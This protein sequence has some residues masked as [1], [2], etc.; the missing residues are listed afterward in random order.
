[1]LG[2]E[3]E[4]FC[5]IRDYECLTGAFEAVSGACE[6]CHHP[7]CETGSFQSL[8]FGKSSDWARTPSVLLPGARRGSIDCP[9]IQR[10]WEIPVTLWD[11]L[12]DVG[13]RSSPNQFEIDPSEVRRPGGC[14][15]PSSQ[16]C[17]LW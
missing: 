1:M 10:F 13:L 4:F 14:S 7:T 11:D 2:V 5:E 15:S 6:R 17:C 12:I 8:T 9:R 16:R 3:S